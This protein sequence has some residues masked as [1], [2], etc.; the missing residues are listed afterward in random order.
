MPQS[1][2]GLTFPTPPAS[3]LKA[4]RLT[5]LPGWGHGQQNP[6]SPALAVPFRRKEGSPES[7]KKAKSSQKRNT[8]GFITPWLCTQAE[9]SSSGGS[10]RTTKA[11]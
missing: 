6:G 10:R 2:K 7:S 11:P 9:N 1:S 5:E 8:G 3:L 4:K